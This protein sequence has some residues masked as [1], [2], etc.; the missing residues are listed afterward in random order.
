[1]DLKHCVE[2]YRDVEGFF[3]WNSKTYKTVHT[4]HVTGN[5]LHIFSLGY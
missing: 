5:A 3:Q 1:M 2:H 4:F